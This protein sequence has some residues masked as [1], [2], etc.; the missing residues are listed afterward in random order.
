MDHIEENIL[1][2]Q[3]L[4]EQYRDNLAANPGISSSNSNAQFSLAS[5]ASTE[6]PAII[7]SLEKTDSLGSLK[8]YE[9]IKNLGKDSSDSSRDRNEG[10]KVQSNPADYEEAS[11]N[12]LN[13]PPSNNLAGMNS[14]SSLNMDKEPNNLSLIK[15][16][17]KYKLNIS[18][19]NSKDFYDSPTNKESS[20]DFQENR[21]RFRYGRAQKAAAYTD[22]NFEKMPGLNQMSGFLNFE[23]GSGLPSPSQKY[24][25]VYFKENPR[26]TVETPGQ[27]FKWPRRQTEE[28][29]VFSRANSKTA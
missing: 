9:T 3:D 20:E 12:P 14:S 4:E 23:L 11:S 10:E 22:I 21:N 19:D 18:D 8:G 7:N 16:E 25:L 13:F 27:R 5:Q 28:F 26:G 15:G 6:S 1:N 29:Q 24:F 2:H 17:S